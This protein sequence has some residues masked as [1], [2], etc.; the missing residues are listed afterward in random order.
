M[1]QDDSSSLSVFFFSP[2]GAFAS[3]MCAKKRQ[4]QNIPKIC[5]F[6]IAALPRWNKPH[7]VI[8]CFSAMAEVKVHMEVV[9]G[10]RVGP[11]S[12][13][14]R[15]GP[16]RAVSSLPWLLFVQSFFSLRVRAVSVPLCVSGWAASVCVSEASL[17]YACSSS[18]L[19][20]TMA[21]RRRVSISSSHATRRTVSR[22]GKVRANLLRTGEITFRGERILYFPLDHA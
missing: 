17:H 13:G 18:R 1:A 21:R 19:A 7:H 11:A 4:A 2:F 15:Q 12:S 14:R 5:A 22:Y 16:T 9:D 10:P 8:P 6:Q 3:D 20:T